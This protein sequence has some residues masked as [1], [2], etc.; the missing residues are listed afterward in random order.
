LLNPS[1]YLEEKNKLHKQKEYL[2]LA[3][4]SQEQV[5]ELL[6]MYIKNFLKCFDIL[7]KKTKDEEKIFELI[8]KLRYFMILPFNIEKSIKDI[9]SLAISIEKTQRKLVQK[10]VEK[11]IIANVPFEIM[12]HVFNTKIIK[13][14]DIFYKITCNKDGKYFVQFFDENVSEEKFEIITVEK[15]KI[16]RKIKIFI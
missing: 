11:K 1:N 12:K 2:E 7:I 5:E 16:N 8:Y 4:Q 15:M 9:E 6:I 10:A 13:L 3:T 14:E